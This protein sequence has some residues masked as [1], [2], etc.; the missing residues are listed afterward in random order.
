VHIFY[1]LI[2]DGHR[3]YSLRPSTLLCFA[4]TSSTAMT[5]RTV[6]LPM[7]GY[8]MQGSELMNTALSV[9]QECPVLCPV[10]CAG[11]YATLHGATD[12]IAILQL[13]DAAAAGGVG[14]LRRQQRCAAADNF[15]PLSVRNSDNITASCSP[16]SE[17]CR[18]V[19]FMQLDKCSVMRT[20]QVFLRIYNLRKQKNR[21][22]VMPS[23]H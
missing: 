15:D 11:Q 6:N 1:F 16:A 19:C 7:V 21:V 2:S 13:T 9:R 5:A 12:H 20:Q 4:T 23:T 10:C 8:V 14:S 17:S 18:L 3:G 22:L